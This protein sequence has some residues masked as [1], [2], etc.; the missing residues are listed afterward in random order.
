M[1]TLFVGNLSWGT[2]S[3]TLSAFLSESGSVTNCD[4]GSVR[5]GRTRGWAIVEC[6]SDQDAANIIARCND[7]D[8]EGRQL[9]CRL[10]Q[11]PDGPARPPKRSGG[12]GGGGNARAAAAPRS[13][14]DPS[15]EDKPENS[16]GLQV[17]V[18][19][20]PWSVTSDML[21]GTFEQI[22]PVDLA[23]V[24][25]HADSGRSKGWGTVR[26]Q[27]VASANDAIVRFGG[28]ELAGRP[29]TVMMDRYN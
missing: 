5:N 21:R 8:L 4:T 28:V 18:R 6:G 25:C 19:N 26:F 17:V 20:L 24:V 12:G 22:G 23:D 11:K 1:S 13:G 7:A 10:D 15:L 14:G 2:T 16:S 9:V 3:E 29:M 27:D